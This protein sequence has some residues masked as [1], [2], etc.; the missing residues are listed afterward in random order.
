[1]WNLLGDLVNVY[2]DAA[3]WAWAAGDSDEM[4]RLVEQAIACL[5]HRKGLGI[6]RSSA[7]M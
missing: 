6:S 5:G 3:S 7:H 1:M 4:Q 2:C